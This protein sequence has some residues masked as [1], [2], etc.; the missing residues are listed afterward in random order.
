MGQHS[1]PLLGVGAGKEDLGND[2]FAR[3]AGREQSRAGIYGH[4]D[5]P[6]G[7]THEVLRLLRLDLLHVFGPR[8][9]GGGGAGQV[10]PQGLAALVEAHPQGRGLARRKAD[11]PGI[12]PVL[13][14]PGLAGRIAGESSGLAAGP[15]QRAPLHG[16]LQQVGHEVGHLRAHDLARAAFGPLARAQLLLHFQHHASAAVLD[17]LDGE[18]GHRPPFVR[19]RGVGARHLQRRHRDHAKAERVLA[20]ERRLYLLRFGNAQHAGGAVDGGVEADLVQHL[21]RGHVHRAGQRGAQQYRSLPLAPIVQ[22]YVFGAVVIDER[23]RGVDD[24]GS[25]REVT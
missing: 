11:R 17:I 25:R 23:D 15:A 8:R 7:G 20:R 6:G 3:R 16:T 10:Q 21:E 9:T 13:G 5:Q 24:H 2:L 19:E 12:G 22:R 1:V 18:R 4:L 14:S